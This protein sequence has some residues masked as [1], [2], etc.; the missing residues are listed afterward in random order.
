MNIMIELCG[1]Y[2]GL[3]TILV[4]G[5]N[6]VYFFRDIMYKRNIRGSYQKL[7]LLFSN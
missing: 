3:I 5:K 1:K 7:V 4:S 2:Y 6:R